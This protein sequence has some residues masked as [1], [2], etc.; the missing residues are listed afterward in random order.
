MKKKIPLAC[1]EFDWCAYFVVICK[2][3]RY[4]IAFSIQLAHTCIMSMTKRYRRCFGGFASSHSVLVVPQ[5][6]ILERIKWNIEPPS[7]PPSR[8]PPPPPPPT[9]GRRPQK[10]KRAIFPSLIWGEGGTN[11][12]SIL[13]TIVAPN[14]SP[15]PYRL[16]P[17]CPKPLFFKRRVFS[18]V[19]KA[20][21]F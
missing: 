2:C 17:N 15:N 12:P 19:K 8:L 18:L 14:L 9:Q 3:H 20:R 16:F 7:S 4:V 21:V 1:I 11:F 5:T 13:S 10:P 6:I